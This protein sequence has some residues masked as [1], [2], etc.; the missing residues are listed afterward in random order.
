MSRSSKLSLPLRLS[1][2]NPV[3]TSPVSNTCHM[4]CPSNSSLNHLNPIWSGLHIINLLV[5]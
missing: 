2:Q 4:P 3:C 5:M 1:H